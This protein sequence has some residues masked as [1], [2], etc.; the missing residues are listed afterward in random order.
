[1][2]SSIYNYIYILDLEGY[3]IIKQL[4]NYIY[5]FI[6]IIMVLYY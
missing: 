4:L 2:E 1:M 5:F 3:G 6:L